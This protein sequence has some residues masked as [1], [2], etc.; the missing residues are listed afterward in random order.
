MQ[1][2]WGE[3]IRNSVR[4]LCAGSIARTSCSCICMCTVSAF[5]SV[6]I[7]RPAGSYTANQERGVISAQLL[8][9][10]CRL[11]ALSVY[12]SVVVVITKCLRSSIINRSKCQYIVLGAVQTCSVYSRVRQPRVSGTLDMGDVVGTRNHQ[13]RQR[14]EI[15]CSKSSL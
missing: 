12:V 1:A 5:S 6:E 8:V 14:V 2:Q 3:K 13:A 9:Y 11:S 4:T 10:Y 7:S 15:A